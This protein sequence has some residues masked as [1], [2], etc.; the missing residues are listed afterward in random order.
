MMN[1]EVCVIWL[2]SLIDVAI[3]TCWS[4]HKSEYHLCI[5]SKQFKEAMLTHVFNCIYSDLDS[6]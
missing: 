6:C 1:E 4:N 3:N 5:P 2:W